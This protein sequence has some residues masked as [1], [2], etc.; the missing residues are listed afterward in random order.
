MYR[1][2]DNDGA[3]RAINELTVVGRYL[4]DH[5]RTPWL[6]WQSDMWPVSFLSGPIERDIPR[7]RLDPVAYLG[8]AGILLI[9]SEE[10]ETRA[11]P[12]EG[13][14]KL[15]PLSDL[16]P[17]IARRWGAEPENELPEL[18]VPEEFRQ[19]FRD[20]ADGKVNF[21]GQAEAGEGMPVDDDGLSAGVA[22]SDSS[23]P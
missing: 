3:A 5:P 20:W 6:T 16:Y 10:K 2:T 19:V 22:R 13:P 21:V 11:L 23:A 9:T 7:S 8:A 17:Y 1:P 4:I 14:Q 15:G 18:P 12:D